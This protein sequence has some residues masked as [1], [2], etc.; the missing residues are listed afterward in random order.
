MKQRPSFATIGAAPPLPPRAKQ[1]LDAVNEINS[2]LTLAYQS[3]TIS[4]YVN[5][6]TVQAALQMWQGKVPEI[7]VSSE[8]INACEGVKAV[9]PIVKKLEAI[10][11]SIPMKVPIDHI[12]FC[13]WRLSDEYQIAMF[14]AEFCR[15]HK[16]LRGRLAT[17]SEKSH[18]TE[19]RKPSFLLVGEDTLDDMFGSS[20][21]SDILPPPTS[22]PPV[23]NAG[24]VTL[25]PP[26]SPLRT[27]HPPAP[28]SDEDIFKAL[29]S[30][31][32]S[33]DSKKES[34][35]SAVISVINTMK[36]QPSFATI[37][38]APP[39]P[40]RAKQILDAVNE[41]NSLLTLAYQSPTIS[42]YVNKVTVQAALQMWQGKVPEIAVSSEEI[43][44]CEGVKA[45]YPIVK[46]LEAICD[47]I[48]M[49][50]PI[51]HIQF[52]LWRLS[53]EY[54]IAMFGA[55][56]CRVHKLL[57]GRLATISERSHNT[58]TRTPSFILAGEDTLEDKF[59]SSTKSNNIPPPPSS[60]P[61]NIN[62]GGVP[63]PPPT[64][65]PPSSSPPPP[66]PPPPRRTVSAEDIFKALQSSE[67]AMEVESAESTAAVMTKQLASAS[68]SSPGVN[69]FVVEAEIITATPAK[70]VGSMS[71]TQ[72]MTPM[73]AATPSATSDTGGVNSLFPSPNPTNIPSNGK[74]P[75]TSSVNTKSPAV[76]KKNTS[77]WPLLATIVIPCLISL[78]FVF[79][80]V[81]NIFYH[82]Y[83]P[84][85]S[86]LNHQLSVQSH[87]FSV[88]FVNYTTSIQ[89]L[90][91]TDHCNDATD[92]YTIGRWW[93]HFAYSSSS[94]GR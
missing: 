75:M 34:T 33:V 92:T 36:Q 31:G 63:L 46:K 2:L 7:A 28:V 83:P 68:A 40:P 37:G 79:L 20:E 94:L 93:G 30:S 3:P 23:I 43:N 38:A 22:P 57:R 60:P 50:V 71:Y 55:E 78:F 87:I 13:L 74:S 32:K 45:V 19:T 56:F 16:L 64:S 88:Y 66:P 67:K 10:C 11:D 85:I 25:P 47:S 12:Q 27:P 61:P 29:Q 48:P 69:T 58:S 54:Q 42:A 4:A 18:N 82:Q 73:S 80:T 91:L 84:T 90:H 53:D 52:C 81:C 77:P 72:S 62:A 15:V 35:A 39:L 76:P 26:T 14:G 9:Y 21:M 41:I 17:E 6:V 70:P 24:G 51:D 1:I 86:P 44:A 59:G 49:K 65:P 8:E 89:L 5:K